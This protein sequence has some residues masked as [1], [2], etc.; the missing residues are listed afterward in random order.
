MRKTRKARTWKLYA[1]LNLF[2]EIAELLDHHP[3]YGP[4]MTPRTDVVAVSIRELLPARARKAKGG[5]R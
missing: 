2:G 5:G 4:T 3:I 1:R